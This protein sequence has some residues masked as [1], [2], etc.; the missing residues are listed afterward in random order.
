LSSGEKVFSHENVPEKSMHESHVKA[1]QASSRKAEQVKSARGNNMRGCSV[2][3]SRPVRGANGFSAAFMDAAHFAFKDAEKLPCDDGCWR[4]PI[5]LSS[6]G[7]TASQSSPLGSAY[8]RGV[9]ET[10]AAQQWNPCEKEKS[11]CAHMRWLSTRLEF[12]R[13][14]GVRPLHKKT[15]PVELFNPAKMSS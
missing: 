13:K 1:M 5:Y 4:I 14:N 6:R 15:T 2:S 7:Q 8:A 10:M 12:K 3:R 11:P 9:L